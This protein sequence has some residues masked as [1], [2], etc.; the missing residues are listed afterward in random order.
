MF[1]LI[2]QDRRDNTTSFTP[3]R[4]SPHHHLGERVDQR[5]ACIQEVGIA[6]LIV[7]VIARMCR[8]QYKMPLW[9]KKVGGTMIPRP[10]CRG[11]KVGGVVSRALLCVWTWSHYRW[12]PAPFYPGFFWTF[13]KLQHKRDSNPSPQCVGQ[14]LNRTCQLM[15]P[16]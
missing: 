4:T 9:E 6:H 1:E 16:G 13:F 8:L 3:H 14:V 7:N 11:C 2:L 5:R 10:A 15:T 12:M